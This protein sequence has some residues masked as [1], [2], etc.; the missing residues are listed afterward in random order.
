MYIFNKYK[1]FCH[2]VTEIALAIPAPNEE[3]YDWKCSAGRGLFAYILLSNEDFKAFRLYCI[4]SR[5]FIS[6]HNIKLRHC[7]LRI[8]LHTEWT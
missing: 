4:L 8:A 3:K 1:Y 5:L 2:L 6:Y 7:D